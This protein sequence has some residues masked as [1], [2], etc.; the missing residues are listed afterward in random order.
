MSVSNFI[1]LAPVEIVE[2]EKADPERTGRKQIKIGK[3]GEEGQKDQL[4]QAWE[5]NILRGG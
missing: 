4:I 1:L 2:K 5:I 3:E